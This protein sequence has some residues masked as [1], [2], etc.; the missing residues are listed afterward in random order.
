M[1]RH[2]PVFLASMSNLF[3]VINATNHEG[4]T[5][6]RRTQETMKGLPEVHLHNLRQTIMVEIHPAN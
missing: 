2:L 5:G 4:R 1:K 3:W 6:F